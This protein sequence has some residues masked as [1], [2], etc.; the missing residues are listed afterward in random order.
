MFKNVLSNATDEADERNGD[1][2]DDSAPSTQRA[3]ST[4]SARRV[5]GDDTPMR[6]APDPDGAQSPP[7]Q[8]PPDAAPDAEPSDSGA[9]DHGQ[10]TRDR[11]PDG[12]EATSSSTTSGQ[13]NPL[14][15]RTKPHVA[16]D[17]RNMAKRV[18]AMVTL[19]FNREPTQGLV[20]EAAIS[21]LK[22]EIEEEG[23]EHRY[24]DYF[25]QWAAR[26]RRE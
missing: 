3:P 2:D 12:D 17:F 20:M 19:E 15:V 1:A 11:R 6:D 24:F 5:Q 25:R 8:S 4:Q 26:Q 7:E 14:T 18:K 22:R 21:M 9:P 10:Q 13:P 16:E 23:I